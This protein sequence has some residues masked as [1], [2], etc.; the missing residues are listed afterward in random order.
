MHEAVVCLGDVLGEALD[1][2]CAFFAHDLYSKTSLAIV[3]PGDRTC[4]W[5]FSWKW[6]GYKNRAIRSMTIQIIILLSKFIKFDL[7]Y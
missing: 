1:L 6:F 3:S 2:T 7:I 4:E 5:F